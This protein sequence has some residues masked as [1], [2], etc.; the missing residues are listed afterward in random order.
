MP[1]SSNQHILLKAVKAASEPA[2]PTKTGQLKRT[3][4]SWIDV[5]TPESILVNTN[6]RALINKH[7]FSLLPGDCQ[8]ELLLLLPEVD[9]Q[10]SADG[11]MKL[12]N[13]A[14][15][16]EFFTSA[17]Q[18]WKER[19]AEGEFTPEMQLRI[20]QELE[21]EKK[22]EPWKEQ[23]YES[24]YGQNSGLSLEEFNEI[25][26]EESTC[27]EATPKP[28][29]DQCTPSTN[30]H[31][32]DLKTEVKVEL[33]SEE[34]DPEEASR[35]EVD[36]KIEAKILQALDSCVEAEITT[37]EPNS[38]P[39]DESTKISEGSTP[40]K[41]LD[42]PSE[43][44]APPKLSVSPTPAK[45][46]EH[47]A[48]SA[49]E[50]CKPKSSEVV[51]TPTVASTSEVIQQEVDV[52]EIPSP[53]QIDSNIE[54]NKRKCADQ[55]GT[56][57][58]PE[59]RT[60]VA[61]P[62][63][64]QQS[65][66][67]IP[68]HFPESTEQPPERKVPPLKIP[69]SRFTAMPFAACQ[70][71]PRAAFPTPVTS[72]GRTGA[73][74]L[75]D[76][77]AKANL[78]RA[79]RAAAAA[80]A[81]AAASVGDSVPGPGPG[82]GG[83]GGGDNRCGSKANETGSQVVTM[84]LG[85][86]GSRGGEGGPVQPHLDIQS[87]AEAA[88]TLASPAHS[89]SRTQLQQTL[90]VQ[91]RAPAGAAGLPSTSDTGNPSAL[92]KINAGTPQCADRN[93][94]DRTN[95]LQTQNSTSS[96]PLQAANSA[97]QEKARSFS[98]GLTS[99][100][101]P[102]SVLSPAVVGHPALSNKPSEVVALRKNVESTPQPNTTLPC[103]GNKGNVLVASSCSSMDNVTVISRA[104]VTPTVSQATVSVSSSVS[105]PLCSTLPMASCLKSQGETSGMKA[106]MSIPS[107]NPLV[108]RLLQG[109]AMPLEKV[110]SKPLKAEIQNVPLTLVEKRKTL[111]PSVAPWSMGSSIASAESHERQPNIAMEHMDRI[112][113][114]SR[115][116]PQVQKPLFSGKDERDTNINQ[117]QSQGTL[118][119]VSQGNIQQIP[120][121]VSVLQPA[122]IYHA[123]ASYPPENVSA[124]HRFMLGFTGRRTCKP[125][126]SGH[127]LLNISTYGRGSESFR[128]AHA[129]NT[130]SQL[131]LNSAEHGPNAD[132][133]EYESEVAEES[134]IDDDGASCTDGEDIEDGP[135]STM[136][137]ATRFV[138][139]RETSPKPNRVDNNLQASSKT[140]KLDPAHLEQEAT[141]K[142]R[143]NLLQGQQSYDE[144]AL[145]RGFIQAAQ[146]RMVNVL[147]GKLIHSTPE[148][149]QLSAPPVDY[150]VHPTPLI[151][152]LQTPRLY[153]NASL[154]GGSSY[155]GVINVSTSPNVN[156]S[157]VLQLGG[158]QD[159]NSTSNVMS[160]SVTVTTI[161][162]GHALNP[163]NH[164][165]PIS[166]KAFTGDGGIDS[167]SKCY[168]RLKAM[169]VC[170]GCGAFCHDDC[171]GPS[172]LCVSCLVVR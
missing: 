167:P 3:K 153:G 103:S 27:E 130:E 114:H 125:A 83:P 169:I 105:T 39:V 85:R 82:G 86:T 141:P 129:P 165:Q 95:N 140:V 15:T 21:K 157:P 61:E 11:L 4:C 155:G 151:S 76:I 128:R 148:L 87:S 118:Y 51:E 20:R 171:I 97:R 8:Q 37:A 23:F 67:I 108:T 52:K 22:V 18:S 172:K 38:T 55:V 99:P 33:E 126:M 32:F 92:E 35:T 102:S 31:L 115:Y 44:E 69:F 29:A 127:Y 12:S 64:D 96:S 88:T 73:R 53:E 119:K 142:Q 46:E 135:E 98:S 42:S 107:T 137:N 143:L 144:A 106:S 152:H 146:A 121:S 84:E 47:N 17:A 63:Q 68:A 41:A 30:S 147:G 158:N 10:A 24:Y 170:K 156:N 116:F 90:N 79:Q 49:V 50:L 159:S 161:P 34:H 70:V 134:D 166:V 7:T 77:K 72:P 81:A 138:D 5:E 62:Q 13:S 110:L 117:P 26:A 16:N 28:P 122:P 139:H 9:R 101:T 74:T 131:F 14:L 145:A 71:S 160:F 132:S 149:Y 75:A 57:L 2:A 78:A 100:Q 104:S 93:H 150:Q 91:S 123:P 111:H 58:S 163:A 124:S 89:G 109:K 1:V 6:L 120:S 48:P 113:H 65:F 164:G 56:S 80:A 25:T 66:R 94:G 168:C 136:V 154:L 36:E 112:I 45:E 40:K 60:R 133:R 19:L 59:K 54:R 43:D 162:A